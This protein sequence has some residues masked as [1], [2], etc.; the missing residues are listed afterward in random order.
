MPIEE[1]LA[2]RA[3]CAHWPGYVFTIDAGDR[4]LSVSRNT[5]V[6]DA[7][8]CLGVDVLDVLPAEEQEETR[9][10]FRSV[11]STGRTIT[12]GSTVT[13]PDGSQRSY[14]SC[15]MPLGGDGT[16]IILLSDVTA[17]AQ[18]REMRDR[19]ER[20]FRALVEKSSEGI[21][22]VAADRSKTYA[23]PTAGKLFGLNGDEREILFTRPVVHPDDR[24]RTEADFQ[25]VLAAP[26]SCAT[27]EF[28]ARHADG[29]W[30]WFE[31]TSTNLLAEPAVGAI[32]CN[33]RDLTD[34]KRLV[35]ELVQ[36]QKMEALGALAG[37]VAHDFNNMLAAVLAYTELCLGDLPESAPMRQDLDAIR[38]VTLRA[39]SLTRQ[40]LAFSRKQ[41]L[42]PCAVALNG[43]VEELGRM[44]RRMIGE[45]VELVTCLEPDLGTISADPTH[46]TQVILNLAVNARDAMR[47]G[48]SLT[49]RT[50][51]IDLD[52]D[53]ARKLGTVSPGRYVE[54][55]VA[56]TGCG[57]DAATIARA[58]E[59]FFTTKGTGKGTG[60]GLSTVLGVVKQ[61]G[62]SI[63]VESAPGQGTTFRI[64]LP[65]V[66]AAPPCKKD[67]HV[68]PLSSVRRV[69][70]VED[71]HHARTALARLLE[72]QGFQVYAASGVAA[73]LRTLENT[74]VDVLLTDVVMCDGDG[75]TLAVTARAKQPGLR[76][77]FMSGY[78]DHPLLRELLLEPTTDFI[79]KPL[80]VDDVCR[81]LN[82][83]GARPVQGTP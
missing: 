25:A 6:H 83:L 1:Q 46:L 54:L 8:T 24:D 76:V 48:G 20:R 77:L 71:D 43:M 12:R 7:E 58:F 3:L 42:Q 14:E 50:S 22:L 59:P 31:S 56:D 15:V 64:Y 5:R 70:V 79:P 35:D 75:P 21:I 2:W 23:S 19:S 36:S 73:A 81:A 67:G 78:S 44:L 40:L 51:N 68:A 47:A 39:T 9:A 34:R 26:G 28:R 10:I 82:A 16:L 57:M 41:V 74:L 38:E 62:G 65:R 27:S 72:Q 49:L 18:A 29:T 4:V 53:G 45:D 61:S 33:F 11:R 80:D 55:S 13:L 32:V 63:A 52:P 60:L 66:D 69:L 17:S 37:G 30:H